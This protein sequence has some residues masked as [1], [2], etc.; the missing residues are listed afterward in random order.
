MWIDPHTMRTRTTCTYF[1][2]FYF[3]PGKFDCF[4]FSVIYMLT[5]GEANEHMYMKACFCSQKW[6]VTANTPETCVWWWWWWFLVVH[7]ICA[8]VFLLQ[9]NARPKTPP[10]YTINRNSCK[11]LF[12]SSFRDAFVFVFTFTFSFSFSFALCISTSLLA[13]WLDGWPAS[14]SFMQCLHH[15]SCTFGVNDIWGAR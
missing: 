7:L 14:Q 11:W 5:W 6:I 3:I 1:V 15:A 2:K 9:I 8:C 4:Q 13:G 12:F 10:V